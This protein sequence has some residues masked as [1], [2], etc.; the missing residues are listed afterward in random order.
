MSAVGKRI[1]TLRLKKGW[2]IADLAEK[3]GISTT[4]ISHYERDL[5]NPDAETIIKLIEIFE[6]SAE[7]LLG[8]SDIVSKEE[9]ENVNSKTGSLDIALDKLP[10]EERE[11]VIFSLERLIEVRNNFTACGKASDRIIDGINGLIL[12][13]LKCSSQAVAIENDEDLLGYDEFVRELYAKDFMRNH[14]DEF[15]RVSNNLFSSLISAM[16]EKIHSKYLP[17]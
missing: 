13:L 4:A 1:K 3:V 5:R 15:N 8:F 16:I 17:A 12:E 6:C 9:Y 7:Y 11:K 14:L 10:F 2:I